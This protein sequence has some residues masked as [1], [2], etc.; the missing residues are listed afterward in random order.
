[1]NAK[2]QLQE[3]RKR[4]DAIDDGMIPLFK[5]RM[6]IS[7]RIAEIKGM[8]NM[9]VTDELRE[10]EVV[11]RAL[12][13][14]EDEDLRGEVSLL[15]RSIIAIS[16]ERQ[17]RTLFPADRPLLP[18]PRKPL[19]GRVVCAFQGVP[20]AWSEQ[21]LAAIF[22][23][24]EKLA[25]EFFEDLFVALRERKADYGVV[26]IENSKTGAIGE[27]Y[28]LLRKYGCYIVA[29]TWI[30]IRHCLLAPAGVAL[31][32]IREV[33]SH[34]EGFRQCAK[35]LRGK[36]W[37]LV[38]CRNTAVAA[39]TAAAKG[40]GKTAAIGSRRAAELNGLRVLV[41]DIMDK[42]GNRTSFVVISPEPEYDEADDLI[43]LTF[44]TKHRSGALCEMLLPFM[45]GGMNLMQ[46]ESR[47]AGAGKYRFFAEVQG[48]ILDA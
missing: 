43:S 48:N 12:A 14:A 36:S 40:T 4:I 28:D 32:D 45:A 13:I 24:A 17:R 7:G 18:P 21:A 47:P 16:K 5:E 38:T 19:Q 42:A 37:D 39:E 1:M 11:D 46:L 25:V 44:S 22:P 41:P 30:D 31:A 9:A 6:E 8:S 27:T 23:E 29:R 15:M 20:G 34:S 33:L 2:E 35:F 10:R 26:A 3:M